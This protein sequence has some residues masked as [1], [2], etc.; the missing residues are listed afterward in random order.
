MID[1]WEFEQ[2]LRGPEET[3]KK[4]M[5][6]YLPYFANCQN[7]L[8]LGCGRGEFLEL[9]KYKKINAVG[10]DSSSLAIQICRSKGLNVIHQDIITYLSQCEDEYDGIILYG[11]VEHFDNNTLCNLLELASRTTRTGGIILISTLNPLSIM[12]QQHLF[13]ADP[14]HVRLYSKEYLAYLINKL[15]FDII[16]CQAEGVS[17][18]FLTSEISLGSYKEFIEGLCRNSTDRI[19][20]EMRHF[21]EMNFSFL[22][23]LVNSI[24]KLELPVEEFIIGI[25]TTQ[26]SNYLTQIVNEIRTSA[27]LPIEEKIEELQ[28]MTLSDII[29]LKDTELKAKAA[30][31]AVIKATNWYKISYKC[32]H[33]WKKVLKIFY[34]KY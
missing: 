5:A 6:K 32:Y 2:Y 26:P 15:G 11:V 3:V 13:Y 4:C 34:A 17:I 28:M 33:F 8:D 21:I 22:T 7:V 31:L 30:E 19:T 1:Y 24:V 14:T 12:A 18:P 27:D 23:S 16:N 25:K 10:V 29:R 20:P 9:L